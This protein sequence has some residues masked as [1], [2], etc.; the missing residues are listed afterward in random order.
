MGENHK[1][2]DPI[3]QPYVVEDVKGFPVVRIPFSKITSVQAPALKALF[4]NMVREGKKFIAV[5]L[6]KVEY[7]DS[8]ALSAL[9][10]GRRLTRDNDGVLVLFGLG[11]WAKKVIEVSELDK[12]FE[13]M[14]DEEQAVDYLILSQIRGELQDGDSNSSDSQ[15]S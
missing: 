15:D 14:D 7:I 10:L 4:T 11:G 5:D 3:N 6:S 13:I 2:P 9:L 8:S 1:A 12:V